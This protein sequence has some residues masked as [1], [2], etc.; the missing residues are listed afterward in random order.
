M[1]AAAG[2]KAGTIIPKPSP[3]AA[4]AGTADMSSE[5]K[6]ATAGATVANLMATLSRLAKILYML[7]RKRLTIPAPDRPFRASPAFFR[8]KTLT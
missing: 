2:S 4:M 5:P 8:P 6:C 3:K 1:P 7:S